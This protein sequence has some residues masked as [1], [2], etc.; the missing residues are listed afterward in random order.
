MMEF[1]CI[2]CNHLLFKEI[3]GGTIEIKCV[4]CKK[5]IRLTV[6]TKDYSDK[7]VEIK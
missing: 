7:E 5:I 2:D 1:R 3:K 6:P 4:R